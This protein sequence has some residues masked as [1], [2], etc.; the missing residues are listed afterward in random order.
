MLKKRLFAFKNI[1]QLTYNY[2]TSKAAYK[3]LEKIIKK[4][5]EN[6]KKIDYGLQMLPDT[7]IRVAEDEYHWLIQPEL[8]AI[9][10]GLKYV[11]KEGYQ[12]YV[13]AIG[14]R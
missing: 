10:D 7:V 8:K 13:N 14:Q 2:K 3:R 6:A 9:K 5:C 12:G 4:E 11:H 1:I